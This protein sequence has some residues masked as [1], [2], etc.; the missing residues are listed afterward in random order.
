MTVGFSLPILLIKVR[1]ELFL[2][3]F[4]GALLGFSITATI[5]FVREGRFNLGRWGRSEPKTVE[6]TPKEEVTQ[7]ASPTPSS[8]QEKKIFLKITEPE[9]EAV[10]AQEELTIKGETLPQATVI[11]VWEEGEDILLADDQGRFE[12]EITLVGGENEIE[13]SAY[14]DEGN[15]A[16]EVLTITYSTAKF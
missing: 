2:A 3:I 7:S 14:D 1:K 6:V 10:V 9:N 8:K 12:T 15:Q 13:I 4:F 11:I 5:W 16:S